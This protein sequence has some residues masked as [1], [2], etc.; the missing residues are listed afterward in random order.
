MRTTEE[1]GGV[2]TAEEEGEDSRG[3]RVRITE[4]GE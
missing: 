1:R 2:R 4:G 3:R